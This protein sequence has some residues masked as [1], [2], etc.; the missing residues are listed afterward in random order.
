MNRETAVLEV[1][2][3]MDEDF[4][5]IDYISDILH[6]CSDSAWEYIQSEVTYRDMEKSYEDKRTILRRKSD[7]KYFAFEWCH[8]SYIAI[9]EYGEWPLKGQEVFPVTKTVTIT[10]YE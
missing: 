10:T 5:E 1:L 2:D 7:G 9:N 6:G 4:D 3:Q 8:S